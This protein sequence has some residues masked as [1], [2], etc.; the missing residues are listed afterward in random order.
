[1][2]LTT[3]SH[4]LNYQKFLKKKIIAID[5]G[6]KVVGLAM[7]KVGDD[8]FPY[9]YSR[10]IYKGD[11]ELI[12]EIKDLK[13]EEFFDIIILGIPYYTDGSSSS[14][15]NHLLKFGELLKESFKNFND[16]DIFY[17]DETLSTNE[18][19]SRMLNSPQYNFK[20]DLKEIDKVAATIILED[21]IKANG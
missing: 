20:I 15:T 17:Q 16:I 1:M 5:Y 2:N 14:M 9:P 21:F 10:I 7:F 12:Q 6:T 4:F 13:G 11:L 8:P 19:K 18:A 3:Y